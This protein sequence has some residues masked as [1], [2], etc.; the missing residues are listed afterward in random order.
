MPGTSAIAARLAGLVAEEAA[1]SNAQESSRAVPVPT[2]AAQLPVPVF[3]SSHGSGAGV[4]GGGVPLTNSL[5]PPQR[6]KSSSIRGEEGP[7]PSTAHGEQPQLQVLHSGS[8]QNTTVVSVDVDLEELS[9]QSTQEPSVGDDGT[10][11]NDSPAKA[12]LLEGVGSKSLPAPSN[13]LVRYLCLR[14]DTNLYCLWYGI[15]QFKCDLAVFVCADINETG[16]GGGG[17]ESYKF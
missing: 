17:G 7:P 10:D 4:V 1:V 6:S 12:L 3:W 14:S 13:T 9:G 8:S 11:G 5:E 2:A 16:E 15:F